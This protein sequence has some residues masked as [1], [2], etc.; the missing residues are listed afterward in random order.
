MTRRVCAPAWYV[1]DRVNTRLVS[2]KSPETL[3]S[4]LA[5]RHSTPRCNGEF[6]NASTWDPI[7][8]LPVKRGLIPYTTP[9][10]WSKQSSWDIYRIPDSQYGYRYHSTHSRMGDNQTKHRVRRPLTHVKQN[11]IR[12]KNPETVAISPTPFTVYHR[13]KSG[14]KNLPSCILLQRLAYDCTGSF[15]TWLASH[16]LLAWLYTLEDFPPLQWHH[17]S[18]SF[19]DPSN[20]CGLSLC[21]VLFLQQLYNLQEKKIIN[22]WGS[23]DHPSPPTWMIPCSLVSS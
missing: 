18:R 23:V 21:N 10:A 5:A 7:R 16:V 4:W 13:A 15:T 17:F 8:L 20:L 19:G 9:T 6:V 3:S 11:K 2:I 14:A 12:L 22:P 1:R